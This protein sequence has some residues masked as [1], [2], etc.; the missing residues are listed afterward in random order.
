MIS[1]HLPHYDVKLGGL[2]SID[3]THKG[4]DK[5]Y[6]MKRLLHFLKIHKSN[7]LFFGDKLN[8]GENDYSIK[9]MGIKSIPVH[10]PE[11]TIKHLKNINNI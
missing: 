3:I 4:I 6:G 10:S 7:V 9:A 2:T 11:E 5:A 8:K 1:K